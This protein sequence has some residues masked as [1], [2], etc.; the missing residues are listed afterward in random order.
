M[1]QLSL[2]LLLTAC[3]APVLAQ[4]DL[5]A[6]LDEL[7]ALAPTEVLA[8]KD[9]YSQTLSY[10]AAVPYRLTVAQ[11]E[12]D[13]RRGDIVEADINLGLLRRARRGAGR[14]D[15]L[16][17]NLTSPGTPSVKLTENGEP[18]GYEEEFGIFA[19]DADNARAMEAL[20]TEIL[21]LAE[22]AYAEASDIPEG[23]ADLETFLA[24]A[25]G[26]V[27]DDD[28]TYEQ[29]LGFDDAGGARLQVTGTAVDDEEHVY[30]F[31]LGDLEARQVE[32]DEAGDLI[33]VTVATRRDAEV[34]AH[35]EDGGER[36]FEDEIGFGLPDY[37]AGLQLA[38]ALRR[39]IPLA[40][41]RDEAGLRDYSSVDEA[42]G[43]LA[44]LLAAAKTTELSQAL[45][46]GCDAVLTVEEGGRSASTNEYAFTFADL[47]ARAADAGADDGLIV[48]E[49]ET[50]GEAD[51]VAR[52]EDG[53]LDGYEDAVEFRFD[54]PRDLD[55]GERAIEYLVGACAAEVPTP[56]IGEVAELLTNDRIGADGEIEQTMTVDEEGCG[57][58]LT[59][60]ETGRGDA[61]ETLSS[62][63]L[64]DLNTRSGE[65]EVR[66]TTVQVVFETD[67]GEELVQVIEDGSDQ[68]YEDEVTFF[69][70]D[71]SAAKAVLK[72]VAAAAEG[73]GARR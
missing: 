14:G 38:E 25:I 60:I 36:E 28:E 67:R 40:R 35:T 50:A 24:G 22:A 73:C 17:V 66:G 70:P 2:A 59:V 65:L 31:R 9:T 29:S 43:A 26:E 44:E 62:F 23:L 10:D 71:L 1:K 61:D 12:L 4:A 34:I 7:I 32:V 63:N 58:E 20:L 68:S 41:E 16:Y 53:E 3:T 27:D 72:G 39:A 11:A 55:R 57:V 49:F 69:A 54:S 52:T 33:E 18:D 47:N 15:A 56:S 51:L 8:G 48:L 5:A 45:A 42:A 46:G 6:K 13:D 30:E 19:A 37:E 64:R 21:A